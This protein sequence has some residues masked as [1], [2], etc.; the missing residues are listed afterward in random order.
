MLGPRCRTDQLGLHPL[1]S[2][3]LLGITK[4]TALVRS[5]EQ[6]DSTPLAVEGHGM[7]G[8]SGDA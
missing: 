3:P 4:G 7:T 2:I 1:G 6:D 8:P 5:A